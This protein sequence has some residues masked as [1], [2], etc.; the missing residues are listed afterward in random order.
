MSNLSTGSVRRTAGNILIFLGGLALIASAA[1]K[2]AHITPVV[3][4]L[5]AIGFDGGR[6][7]IIATLEV[8][9][10]AMF[11][12]PRTRSIGLL[13]I[14][15][16][17]GGAIAAHLGHREPVYQRAFVLA[18]LSIGAYLRH[19]GILWGLKHS[20]GYGRQAARRASRH[21]AHRRNTTRLL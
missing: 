14:S 11:L 8:F 2:F 19:P 9:S 6:L 18:L 20:I 16:Y 15:S 4:Q 13:L 7:M 21:A 3:N 10:A 1:T 12:I 17:M 5:T